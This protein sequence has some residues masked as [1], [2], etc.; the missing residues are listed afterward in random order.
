MVQNSSARLITGTKK[1]DHITPVLRELHWLPVKQRVVFKIVL[2]TYKALND[3]GPSYLKELLHPYTPC[4]DGLRITNM[5]LLQEP[6]TNYINTERRAF[7]AAAPREW[8]RLPLYIKLKPSVD[9]F[10]SALKTFLFN[11]AYN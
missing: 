2:L 6:K 7:G 4:R 5:G 11:S 8:N 9:S 1:R 3:I 10:K